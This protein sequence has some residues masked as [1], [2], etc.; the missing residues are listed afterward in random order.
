MNF[1]YEETQRDTR[2]VSLHQTNNQPGSTNDNIDNSDELELADNDEVANIVESKLNLDNI[3][4]D[5]K[6]E[7]YTEVTRIVRKSLHVG[8][9]PPPEQL[10]KYNKIIPNGAERIM[11]IAENEQHHSITMEAKMLTATIWTTRLGQIFGLVIGLTVIILGFICI[12]MGHDLS[13]TAMSGLGVTGLVSIF[14]IGRKRREGRGVSVCTV[15][16]RCFFR[17]AKTGHPC[18][19]TGHFLS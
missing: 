18:T 10:A 12:M 7:I 3:P 19:E 16:L 4:E 2:K 11:R 1:I 13:G 15:S 5:K 14:V 6:R 8:P 9:L 17:P